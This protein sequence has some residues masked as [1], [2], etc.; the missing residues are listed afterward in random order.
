MIFPAQ[1]NWCLQT[2]LHLVMLALCGGLLAAAFGV[3]LKDHSAFKLFPVALWS[4]Y[5]VVYVARFFFT[6]YELT[7]A[8]LIV[9]EGFSRVTIPLDQI[10]TVAPTR[11]GFIGEGWSHDALKIRF[12]REQGVPASIV[13][14][15]AVQGRLSGGIDGPPSQAAALW[16]GAENCRL[17]LRFSAA[18]Q[19]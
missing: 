9:R 14:F 13:V 15:T 19:R 16:R 2:I 10:L 5:A 3:F 6:S 18:S 12:S 17:R 8:D 7:D 1:R 4:V 11:G